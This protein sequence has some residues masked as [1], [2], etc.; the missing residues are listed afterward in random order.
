VNLLIVRSLVLPVF[1]TLVSSCNGATPPNVQS[2]A[3]FRR[4]PSSD[5]HLY[6]VDSVGGKIYRYPLSNGL[7]QA[8]PDEVFATV[9]NGKFLGVDRAHNIYVAGSNTSTGFVEKFSPKGSPLGTA[10]LG[11]TVAAF[12][13]DAD[14]YFYVV[15]GT[16]AGEVYTY[17]P[18]AIGSGS[19]AQ[20]VAVLTGKT[21]GGGGYES[22]GL[23]IEGRAPLYQA[24][25]LW[26]NVFDHPRKTSYESV[27]IKRPR[28][29]F[30]PYFDGALAVTGSGQLYA[31][32]G[33]GDYCEGS[34]RSCRPYYWYLT[35]FGA[36]SRDLV[37]DKFNVIRAR[38]CFFAGSSGAR[39]RA[40]PSSGSFYYRS[41]GVV[42]G[43]AVFDGYVDAACTG[44][45]S[46]VWVYRADD[47]VHQKPVE[48]LS[49]PTI[50]TDAKIGP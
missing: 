18:S 32:I 12:A 19:T 39:R 1:A 9:A 30:A 29:G 5:V 27:A 34:R 25:I 35:D 21:Q 40:Q 11:V 45:A 48:V 2:S 26:I 36:I 37:R 20:P 6:V 46:A 41:S 4:A 28:L 33:F 22:P 14:G 50:P 49:G 43:M 3:A 15:P 24:G 16:N 44:D 8:T 47:F 13:T 23:A 10:Q 42:T 38:N 7:P 17:S 31:N